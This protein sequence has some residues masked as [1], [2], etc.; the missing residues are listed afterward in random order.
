MIREIYF[1]FIFCIVLMEIPKSLCCLGKLNVTIV[2]ALLLHLVWPC[3]ASQVHINS[4]NLGL[5]FKPRFENSK[6]TFILQTGVLNFKPGSQL[7]KC[8]FIL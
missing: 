1:F 8:T 7:T 6:C 4:L 2:F 5:N 3:I